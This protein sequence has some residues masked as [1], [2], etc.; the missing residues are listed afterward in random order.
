[1]TESDI[2]RLI[3]KLIRNP[4]LLI[5]EISPRKDIRTPGPRLERAEERQH[6][7]EPIRDL[8]TGRSESLKITFARIQ[9]TDAYLLYRVGLTVLERCRPHDFE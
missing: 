9:D 3:L 7:G 6:F 5:G 4:E 1:M 8:V 2:S